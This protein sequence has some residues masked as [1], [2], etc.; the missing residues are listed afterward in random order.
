VFSVFRGKK[1]RE[2]TTK[3]TKYTKFIRCVLI[4]I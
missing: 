1:I 3:R 4:P 2:L